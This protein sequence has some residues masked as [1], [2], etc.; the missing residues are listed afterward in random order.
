MKED[1]FDEMFRDIYK[2]RDKL[3]SEFARL[4]AEPCS[5]VP[6]VG[7][8]VLIAAGLVG[9]G[10]L[11]IRLE[12]VV[13]ECADTAYYVKYKKYKLYRDTDTHEEW[14]HQAVITDVLGE[15]NEHI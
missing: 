13:L 12:A 10:H 11:W 1:S 15:N 4:A 7:D 5:K 14:V 8:R 9:K 3:D 6:Q 2:Y